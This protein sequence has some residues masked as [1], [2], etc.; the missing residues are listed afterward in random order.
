MCGFLLVFLFWWKGFES[1]C[2]GFLSFLL[3]AFHCG[4]IV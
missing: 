2:G 4:Y 3:G 1:V